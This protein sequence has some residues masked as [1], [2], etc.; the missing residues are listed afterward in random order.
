VGFV[1]LGTQMR[2][3]IRNPA[4]GAVFAQGNRTK[5]AETLTY[6]DL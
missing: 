2:A 1:E 3:T 5:T 4:N 6:L